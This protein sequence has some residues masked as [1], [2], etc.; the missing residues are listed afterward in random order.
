MRTFGET[1]KIEKESLVAWNF[2]ME[3]ISSEKIEDNFLE[4]IYVATCC[5]K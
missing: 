1:E 4:N 5:V 3:T 2:V